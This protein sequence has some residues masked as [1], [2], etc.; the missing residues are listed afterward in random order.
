MDVK[1]GNTS[2]EF[3]ILSLPEW[4]KAFINT[5]TFK[6][7]ADAF[8]DWL[9]CKKNSQ[10][11]REV[12]KLANENFQHLCDSDPSGEREKYL[13]KLEREKKERRLDQLYLQ[14]KEQMI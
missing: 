4:K 3:L 8:E 13:Q 2:R 11:K 5:Q 7:L 1:P 6:F 10:E 9:E 12:L 14:H